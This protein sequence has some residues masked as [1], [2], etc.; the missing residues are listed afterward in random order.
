MPDPRNS[1]VFAVDAGTIGMTNDDRVLANEVRRRGID[2]RPVVW[3]TQLSAGELVVIRSPYDYVERPAEFR[4]WLDA[5]DAAGV[6][7]VNPTPLLR[8]NMHKGYLAELGANGVGVVPTEML[9][10]GST[11]PLVDVIADRGWSRVVVKPAIGASARH[12]I[13]VDGADVAALADAGEHL[14]R[15][16]ATADM[17]VQPFIP[18]I[19]TDGEVSVVVLSGEITHAVIKRPSVGEWRVQSDFGGSAL[20]VPVTAE[21]ER[22]VAEV[23]DA[24]AGLVDE[25]PVYARVD[26]VRVDTELHLMELEVIEPDLFFQLAPEAAD[27]F[28]D[29]LAA[30]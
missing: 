30:T 22:A 9:R 2:V 13:N 4:R 7:A 8:W 1:V 28:A 6:T 15:L 19:E 16:V 25:A 12:T 3:G 20:R 23:L 10:A 24:V 26:L 11:R 14:R 17:L 29:L 5:L 27:R 18:S 21:H